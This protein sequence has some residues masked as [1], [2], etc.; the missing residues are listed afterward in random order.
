MEEAEGEEGEAR[1]EN[2]EVR[3]RKMGRKVN[4]VRRKREED[5]G[6]GQQ[7]FGKV[8]VDLE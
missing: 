8:K 7:V 1:R 3:V 6:E 5:E 2:F 4:K